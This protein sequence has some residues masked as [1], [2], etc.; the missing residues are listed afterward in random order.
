[1]YKKWFSCKRNKKDEKVKNVGIYFYSGNSKCVRIEYI[2]D[3]VKEQFETFD[4]L[5]EIKT[6]VAPDYDLG[7]ESDWVDSVI[8]NQYVTIMWLY[9]KLNDYCFKK[10]GPD[11]SYRLKGIVEKKGGEQ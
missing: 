4:K 6:E 11:A 10:Y 7:Y 5:I 1:M 3:L 2:R 9:N 8:K